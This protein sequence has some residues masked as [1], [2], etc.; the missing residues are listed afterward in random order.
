MNTIEHALDVGVVASV[1]PT[2]GQSIR[3]D[4]FHDKFSD[5]RGHEYEIPTRV[6]VIPVL[7]NHW[8]R[9]ELFRYHVMALYEP[10]FV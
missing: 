10:S 1:S 7:Y 6:H 3:A 2:V 9:F 4:T 8:V 5:G